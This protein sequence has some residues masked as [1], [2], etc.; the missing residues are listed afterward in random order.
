MRRGAEYHGIFFPPRQLKEVDY[1]GR[2]GRVP[3]AP[4]PPDIPDEVDTKAS[5]VRGNERTS[6]GNRK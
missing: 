4:P 3:L 6:K 1:P 5:K 2:S